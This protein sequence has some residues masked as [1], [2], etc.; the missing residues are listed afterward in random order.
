MADQ[1]IP[2][3]VKIIAVFYYIGAVLSIIFGILLLVIGGFLRNAIPILGTLGFFGGIILIVLGIFGIFIGRGLWKGKNWARVVATI[4]ATLVTLLTI[5]SFVQILT[6]YFG[7]AY[8]VGGIIS[9]FI[10]LL[11]NLAINLAIA[12]Y[13]AFNSKVKTSFLYS[14]KV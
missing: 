5:V 10:K 13:L 8:I 2:T 12:S 1:K 7:E 3:G 11:I 14:E 9:N 4:V 6:A